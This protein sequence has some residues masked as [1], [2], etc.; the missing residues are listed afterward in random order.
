MP[1]PASVVGNG[2]YAVLVRPTGTGFSAWDGLAL[3]HFSADPTIDGGGLV[4]YL[5]DPTDGRLWSVG[6]AP[7]GDAYDGYTA[8]AEA[9]RVI[10]ARQDGVL[11]TELETWVAADA[12]VELRRLTIRNRG[13]V[14]RTLEVATYAEVV[15]HD[16]AWHL[17][18]PAFAKLFVET[19]AMGG[20]LLARRRPRSRD[21][22]TPC[23][24]HALLG[25]GRLEWDTAR[26]SVLGRGYHLG[27]PRGLA[28]SQPLA[29]TIGSVLDPVLCMRRRVE[30]A[31]GGMAT[32]VVVLGAGGS[33]DEVTA[34]GRRFVDV[35]ASA[36]V[37]AATIGAGALLPELEAAAQTVH[38]VAAR[39]AWPRGGEGVRHDAPSAA[40]GF[41][42][43]GRE[44]VL[45]VDP[46]DP[47]A[48][49]LP[50]MPWVNVIANPT[51]GFIASETGA[52]CTWSRN[53]RE[54]RLTP[55]ANDPIVDPHGEA[56]WIRD[57]DSGAC[58]S[59]QPGPTPADVAYECRHGFGYSRWSHETNDLACEV[60]AGVAPDDP[61]KLV[62]VRITNRSA[63][64]RR[65][66]VVGYAQLVL[67]V[68]PGASLETGRTE[69]NVLWA[70]Q[71]ASG[72]FA[73]G[74]AFA[75]AVVPDGAT[76]SWTTDRTTFLGRGGTVTEPA[77]LATDAPLDDRAGDDPCFGL[78]ARITIA[79][80]RVAAVTFLL[81]ETPDVDTAAAL[82]ARL[83]TAGAVE[84]TLAEV[85]ARWRE[86]LAAV[87]IETPSAALDRMVNGWLLYQTLAC[88]MWGRSALYQ[89]GGA[90]G[91]RDQL[92]DAMAL[93]YARP[94]L[95]RA[96]IVLHAGHQFVEG[97]VLHW[98][99][100]PMDRGTRTRFS[101][102]L[103]WLPW[104]T[105]FYVGTTGDDAVLDEE[106]PFV[107]AQ[108]LAPGEDE[109][110]LKAEQSSERATVYEHCCRA[111]DRSLAVGAHGLPLM[112]TGDWNDGMNRVGR[113]G[114]GE[115]VWMGWFL[116]ALLGAFGP[117]CVARG[118]PE[119]DAR[120]R[121]HRGKL[122]RA[123]EHA[124]WD[125]AWYRRA[126]YDDGAPIGSK[127]SDE[128]RIDALAQAWA[129]ISRAAPRDRAD[130]AMDAV[131]RH[132]VSNEHKLIRLLT[133][134]FEN[135]P[136]DPGYIKGYVPGVRENGGQYTHAALWVVK[137]MAELGRNDRAAELL[138]MLNPVNHARTADD[139]A[140]YRVEPY[141][142][143][144]DVYGEPPHVGRGGWTWYTGSAGWMLRVAVESI[145]GVRMI[146]GD[147]FVI[148]PCIP[149]SWPGYRVH[150]RDARDGTRYDIE[151]VR[152]GA[153]PRV[154][155]AQIDGIPASIV[156]GAARI[157]L[158]RDGALHSIRVLLG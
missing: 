107:T 135:T 151:V 64:E 10:I 154:T 101:D 35:E 31:P 24:V 54:H 152:G 69:A 129:V 17:G 78:R 6:A 61:V 149:G 98:W 130:V 99:H 59:A 119:R 80:G 131:E 55:W 106:A 8:T 122:R 33:L 85:R 22:R 13:D 112:G 44:Y 155:A 73:D 132:L 48:P 65:L 141:V 93:V 145:L 94:D 84:A 11:V 102:D 83:A 156:G 36:H 5:R 42:V 26:A 96:Q 40:D 58:W 25:P 92:Q 2:R 103:L 120:Y 144:A 113:E 28:T 45:R 15:L 56:V 38:E 52:G 63:R 97:D 111:I 137:A 34:L 95:T 138:A 1:R 4:V 77:A 125:G 70:R 29:G 118:E 62:S 41:S 110:Y 47:T 30:I 91:F 89:S 18:H 37:E 43:D 121:A 140:T 139:V 60:I 50:P 49:R 115:S 116:Y 136:R 126:Y 100:P 68:D 72:D 7:A 76:V 12:D 148:H 147:T 114:R 53:S 109:A 27:R 142:V 153:S 105:A 117:L 88:R 127:Q 23:L 20:M 3:T 133:P 124:G 143:A 46:R 71:R 67:G 57:D 81:G 158:A 19:H 75:A 21:E 82:H 108:P 32:L 87:E 104:V 146:G 123:L 16:P 14:A 79:P 86:V 66:S 90:F 128:C 157:P 39:P 134:P 74:V 150:Y 9:G 51:F